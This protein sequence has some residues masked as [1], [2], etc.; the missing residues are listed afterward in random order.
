MVVQFFLTRNG[1][2]STFLFVNISYL[3]NRCWIQF[4]PC[5]H[6]GFFHLLRSV[7]AGNQVAC[8]N[9]SKE[10]LL[11]CINQWWKTAAL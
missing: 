7:C 8:V 5:W 6:S 9:V 11:L 10:K 3:F 1:W 4:S 2:F